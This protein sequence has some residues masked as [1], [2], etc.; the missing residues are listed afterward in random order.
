M[1]KGFTVVE[2]IVSFS[3]AAV[4]VMFLTQIIIGLNKMKQNSGVKTEILNKQSVISNYINKRLLDKTLISLSSCGE[5]C[6]NFN[7]DD[8]TTDRFEMNYI[9]NIL[10][11]GDLKANLPEDTSFQRV[12]FDTIH[13]NRIGT[14][15]DTLLKITIPIA[16]KRFQNE[17]FN[18]EII[19]P[20]NSSV[21]SNN[22]QF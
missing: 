15:N 12:I 2:L 14:G 13:T 16:N 11:F 10:M 8:N 17:D 7:Y 20:Y 21:Y 5:D 4:I 19:Y 18:V 3:L 6:V 1:K 9:T 22:L